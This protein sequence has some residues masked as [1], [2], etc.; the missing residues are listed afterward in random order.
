VFGKRLE[1]EEKADFIPFGE[2]VGE[3][4]V[5]SAVRKGK[6]KGQGKRTAPGASTSKAASS[7]SA[8][9]STDSDHFEV[10]RTTWATPGWREFHRR[11]QLFAL[12]YIEGASYIHEDE[13]NWQWLTTW[14]KSVDDESRS[15]YVFVGYTR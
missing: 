14:H 11:M 5:P 2:K 15:K 10:Y 6:G 13:E 12:L 9:S 7:S 8:A 1:E 3:Y 4:D